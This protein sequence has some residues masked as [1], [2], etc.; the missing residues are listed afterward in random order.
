[1]KHFFWFLSLIGLL[2]PLLGYSQLTMPLSR[3]VFQRG[4]DNRAAVPIQGKCPASATSIQ[5][6]VKAINGGVS[7]DWTTI[8][9]T[10]GGTFSGNLNLPG[11]WY[12]LQVRALSGGAEVGSWSLDRF[13]VG[14]VFVIA[15]QSNAY[16]S[17]YAQNIAAQDDRVSTL[18]Y[19]NFPAGT[20]DEQ[21]LPKAFVQ[22]GAG[23]PIG[24]HNPMLIW[25]GLGDKLVARLGVP[26][27]FLGAAYP[28]SSSSEWRDA[29]NGVEN[30]GAMNKE[31]PYR[32]LGVTLAY[33]IKRTGIRSILW[34][35]G[36]ADNGIT[37]KKE[38]VNNIT[39]VINKSRL[40]S[41]FKNLGWMISSVSYNG[42]NAGHET[43]PAIL[44]AQNQLITQ[45]DNTFPG[46]ATD[47]YTGPYYRYDKV[48]FNDS[49]YPFYLNLWNKA[50]TND[51]FARCKPSQPAV[52]PTIT[53]GYIF[54]MN[55]NGGDHIQVPFM[56]TAP[57]NDNNQYVVKLLSETGELLDSLGAGTRIAPN[58]L[59]VQLPVWADGRVRVQISSTSPARTGEASDVFY[60]HK[61]GE[62]PVTP[63]DTTPATPVR[64]VIDPQG[65]VDMSDCE[66]QYGWARDAAV[67]NL[68]V[69]VV[70]SWDNKPIETQL[71]E[72]FRQDLA[73]AFGD[74]GQ[75][76][77]QWDIPASLRTA[78][79]HKVSIQVAGASLPFFTGTVFC[80]AVGGRLATPGL[81]ETRLTWR[82]FPNPT[83]DYVTVRLPVAYTREKITLTVLSASG[84]QQPTASL[85]VDDQQLRVNLS[86][87]PTGIYLLRLD[88]N[89]RPVTTLTVLKQ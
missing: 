79:N 23:M 51:F 72:R 89:E 68:S 31:A 22:A 87:L 12:S 53:T 83:T 82:V 8:G 77:F 81:E 15:G 61:T 86:G 64:T 56:S 21:N 6:K 60:A 28:G 38:Y 80:G 13:G 32:L 1:M 39:T 59:A 74:N 42:L 57:V 26:V 48:H 30:V 63:P 52:V 25:G 33:F 78:G 36:E 11:G 73:D 75:H 84:Q 10:T 17:P 37:T 55:P 66:H 71:A 24:P 5:V 41:G 16:G 76:G 20:I 29:A 46:V 3:I 19:F 18:N 4:L 54:P 85:P 9:A 43:D 49:I 44:D 7:Q 45:T 40:Q 67:A 47:A 69:P 35:Q 65:W 88:V 58:L 34:H 2:I 50:L 70:F 62:K 27:L 14:E